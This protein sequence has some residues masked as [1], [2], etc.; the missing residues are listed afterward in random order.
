MGPARGVRSIGAVRARAVLVPGRGT[1]GILQPADQV[2]ELVG[3]G[4]GALE[5][6]QP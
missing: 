1:G 5:R 4:L 3:E 2:I 6:P